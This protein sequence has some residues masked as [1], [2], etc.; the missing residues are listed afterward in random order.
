MGTLKVMMK[1]FT[2]LPVD[3]VIKKMSEDQVKGV[4][5]YLSHLQSGSGFLNDIHHQSGDISR[6]KAST[7]IIHSQYDG[8]NPVSHAE[9]AA[10]YIPNTELFIT[11][12]ESHLI[13]FSKHNEQIEQK[14]IEFLK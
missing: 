4:I 2:I 3:G 11:E 1:S 7:L 9:Y 13:W 8:S 6:I 12:A 10:E 14:M 5:E